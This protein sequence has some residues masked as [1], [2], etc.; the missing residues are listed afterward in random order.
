MLPKFPIVPYSQLLSKR[1]I[2]GQL[3]IIDRKQTVFTPLIAHPLQWGG[4]TSTA[5]DEVLIVKSAD[6]HNWGATQ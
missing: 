2:R 6:G 3:A 5:G 1:V 4:D